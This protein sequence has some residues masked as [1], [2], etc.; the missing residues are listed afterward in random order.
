MKPWIVCDCLNR[1]AGHNGHDYE[2]LSIMEEIREA[3]LIINSFYTRRSVDTAMP[4]NIWIIAW[5]RKQIAL[6]V[7][8]IAQITCAIMLFI[9]VA[10]FYAKSR[11]IRQVA[12][13]DA[14]AANKRYV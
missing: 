10:D 6:S 2:I 4:I 5:R 11:K 7:P 12:S 14:D 13:D 1:Q 9:A 3:G 8:W